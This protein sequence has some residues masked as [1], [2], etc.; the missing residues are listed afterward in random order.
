MLPLLWNI[1]AL[2]ILTGGYYRADHP[3]LNDTDW[4][5]F[6]AS[7]Y[8]PQ[9]GDWHLSKLPVHHIID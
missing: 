9:T 5:V 1:G 7:R 3:K 8:D 6:T 2:M 4:H